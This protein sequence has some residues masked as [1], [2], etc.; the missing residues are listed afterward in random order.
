MKL[1]ENKLLESYDFSVMISYGIVKDK[2]GMG[3]IGKIH[4]LNLL[5]LDFR[6]LNPKN[7][8]SRMWG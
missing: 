3:D 8:W 6:L 5:T 1:W 7:S 2:H 4:F